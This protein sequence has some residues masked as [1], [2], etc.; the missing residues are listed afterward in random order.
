[1]SPDFRYGRTL[2]T[3][4][5]LYMVRDPPIRNR[6]GAPL[7]SP[8]SRRGRDFSPFHPHPTDD[9]YGARQRK[10]LSGKI[11]VMGVSFRSGC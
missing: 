3:S 6:T 11:E 4:P 1:M 10:E 2:T 9:V 8:L 5:V 7:C